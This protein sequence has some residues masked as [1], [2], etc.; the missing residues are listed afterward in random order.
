MSSADER[1]QRQMDLYKEDGEKRTITVEGTSELMEAPDLVHLTFKTK[2]EAS[3]LQGAIR[4]CMDK[5]STLRAIAVGCG[6][7]NRNIAS[8]SIGTRSKRLE[9]G[10]HM[11]PTRKQVEEGEYDEDD[12]V[13]KMSSSKVVFEA[14]AVVRVTLQV[15]PPAP[16]A[17]DEGEGASGA[18]EEEEVES[19]DSTG[20]LSLE[21]SKLFSKVCYSLLNSPDSIVVMN[22]APVYELSD[23]TN[24]R[25]EA[26]KDACFN[27]KQKATFIIDALGNPSVKLGKPV[28]FTDVHI[29][30]ADGDAQNSFMGNFGN[31]DFPSSTVRIDLDQ[32][33]GSDDAGAREADATDKKRKRTSEAPAGGKRRRTCDISDDGRGDEHDDEIKT[34][35]DEEIASIFTVP[36]IKV[37]A[38][39][40]AVFEVDTDVKI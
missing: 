22:G 11:P 9:Y 37:A 31:S 6:V 39:I 17:I 28:C 34:L 8:D 30:I 1:L 33:E 10:R 24:L 23:I 36:P 18:G 5:I 38:C 35:G 16:A 21:I 19:D 29:D 15:D 4:G 2:A 13:W 12:K 7:S 32:E 14:E 20:T 3:N 25:N 27:A 40:K 26:R